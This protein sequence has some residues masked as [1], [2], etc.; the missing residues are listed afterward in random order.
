MEE[1]HALDAFGALS[2]ETR[3][4]AF[5]LLVKAGKAGLPAGDIAA[6]LG[7][8]A[9]TLSTHLGVLERARLIRSWRVQRNIFYALEFAGVQRL[10]AFLMEDCC[11]RRA[12]LVGDVARRVARTCC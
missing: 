11:Q 1:K 10:L 8:P 7:V 6:A 9:S 4:A 5:R 3:L 2:Q 12:E